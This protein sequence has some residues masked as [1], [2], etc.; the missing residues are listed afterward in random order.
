VVR[1]K[2]ASRSDPEPLHFS[3]PFARILTE[4]LKV[5]DTYAIHCKL[6]TVTTG[7]IIQKLILG[8]YGGKEWS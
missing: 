8:K 3:Q 4:L 7:R 1:V 2:P 6:P 5:T